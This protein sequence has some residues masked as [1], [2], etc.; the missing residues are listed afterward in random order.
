MNN[1]FSIVTA[2]ETN[3]Y[4]S[5]MEEKHEAKTTETI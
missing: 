4:Y 5:G 2:L 3:D 1:V